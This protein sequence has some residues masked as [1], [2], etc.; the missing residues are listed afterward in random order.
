MDI[1]V[2]PMTYL[3]N[4]KARKNFFNH[5]DLENENRKTLIIFDE[6]HNLFEEAAIGQS[7]QI[8]YS[9]LTENLRILDNINQLAN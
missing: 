7:Y 6:G 5:F 2:C 9:F 3:M 8:S 1:I 4:R